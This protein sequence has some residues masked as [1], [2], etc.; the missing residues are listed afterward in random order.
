MPICQTELRSFYKQRWIGGQE[1]PEYQ[2]LDENT[3]P[4]QVLFVG[5]RTQFALL[6]FEAGSHVHGPDL[7]PKRD[8]SPPARRLWDAG[9]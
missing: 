3:H 7:I 5:R 8:I 2:P 6:R 4:A 9:S 1:M